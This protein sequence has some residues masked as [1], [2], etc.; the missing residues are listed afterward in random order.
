MTVLNRSR[1]FGSFDH[2][3]FRQSLAG[4]GMDTRQWCSFGVVNP[5]E[6]S[7]QRAVEYTEDYGPLV[8]VT[9][10]PS[11]IPVRCRVASRGAGSGEADGEPFAAG[12]EVIV[13]VPEGDER[14]GCVIIGRLNNK[15]SPHP[16]VV[17]GMTLENNLTF[18]RRIGPIAMESDTAI[19]FRVSK[20]SSFLS[21]SQ[22]GNITLTSGD[23]SYLHIGSD[24]LG[25]QNGDATMILQADQNHKEW[26]MEVHDDPDSS[27]F[28]LSGTHTALMSS[29]P[30]VI[31]SAGQ[32]P[33]M[34]LVT[35][36]QMAYFV[37]QV[38]T[39]YG[40]AQAIPSI[41]ATPQQVA[42][43]AIVPVLTAPVLPLDALSP[44][45]SAAMRLAFSNPATNG[46]SGFSALT[47]LATNIIAS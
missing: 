39:F 33:W 7:S 29:Q 14:S 44:G 16:S 11:G 40:L 1:T 12:D 36:E 10:E 26:R 28:R 4:P 35:F 32:Q 17:A 47:G 41:L 46:Q 19:V 45:L 3:S 20:T 8:S 38:L 18:T 31:S 34:H 22:D 15:L 24:F 42:T 43:Q 37:T 21:L 27:F 9:L 25:L 13:I 30:I 5:D 6:G 2:A 23:Q